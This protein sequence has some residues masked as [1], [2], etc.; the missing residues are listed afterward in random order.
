MSI[1]EIVLVSI[2]SMVFW[3]VLIY[4]VG[5]KMGYYHAILREEFEQRWEGESTDSKRKGV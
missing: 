5:F 4:L 2:V 1:G 3:S